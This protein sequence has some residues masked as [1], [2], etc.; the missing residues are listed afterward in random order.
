MISEQV[1]SEIDKVTGWLQKNGAD[2]LYE[3]AMTCPTSRILEMGSFVGKSACVLATAMKERNG[4]VICS[5]IFAKNMKYWGKPGVIFPD[6]LQSFW[7][8]I[9]GLKLQD[10]IITIKGNHI[11]L[12]DTVRGKFGMVYI[13]GGHTAKYI[14][15]D[16]LYAWEHTIEGGYVVFDD[17]GN[18][19]WPDVKICVDV[20]L[21]KWEREIHK[22]AGFVVAIRR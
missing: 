15:P 2:L 16:A 22:Q 20:M 5:D 14:I 19:K 7:D 8:N 9:T 6:T 13:D 4:V 17:Y 11:V 18:V 21:K 1:F 3:C 12:I 10:Y